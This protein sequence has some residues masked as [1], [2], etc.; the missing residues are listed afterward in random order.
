VSSFRGW[1]A[2]P[3]IQTAGQ[4]F[5]ITSGESCP[6]V[7]FRGFGR[8]AG[9][10]SLGSSPLIEHRVV[11]NSIPFWA[12]QYPV[13][14]TLQAGKG[15]RSPGLSGYYSTRCGTVKELDNAK[16]HPM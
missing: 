3:C 6:R 7:K 1:T 2:K 9:N 13:P 4:M 5:S 10:R 14:T 12:A 8:A 15:R 11:K 16:S